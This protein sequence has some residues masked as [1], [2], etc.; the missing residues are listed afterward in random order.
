MTSIKAK[1]IN[2]VIKIPLLSTMVYKW[3]RNHEIQLAS[4]DPR[5]NAN[6]VY[7]SV[8]HKNIDW[9]FPKDLI[10]KIYWLQ[11]FTD[12]SLW[13]LCADKYRMREFVESKGCSDILP[14]LYG[15]W[16]RAEDIEFSIL[17]DKF[18]L[19][20]TNG[21]GQVL[22]VKDRHKLNISKTRKLLNNWM[23][24][25]YGFTDA[26]IHYSRIPPCIIAEEM[27]FEK[28]A[29]SDASLIDYKVWCFH[30]KPE[31]ILVVYDRIILG[32][33]QGY[34][35][36]V[37]DLEW[38]NISARALRKGNKHYKGTDVPKPTRLTD[39][40]KYAEKLSKDFVEV[41]VDF[42]ETDGRLTL[43]ELTFTTGY[44]SYTTEFYEYLGSKID[45]CKVK[46]IDNM[47]CPDISMLTL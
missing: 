28:N 22:I 30:G 37:Y 36:S 18:V 27:L 15:H 29:E 14:M 3:R 11:L 43:G 34:S 38:N 13:T 41:R 6:R 20:T 8:F 33:N 24:L 32:K 23:Q 31:Y 5:N 7:S 45:L 17:P 9:E 2:T 19:K 35:L 21:C 16:E 44:G 4:D 10:E 40:L 25:K 47:N 12:T 39:M 26:Q 46:R 1:I 42:Y